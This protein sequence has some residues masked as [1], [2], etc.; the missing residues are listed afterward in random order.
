MTGNKQTRGVRTSECGNADSR[1]A[2]PPEVEEFAVEK[3]IGP[4]LPAVIALA[5]QAFPSASLFVSVGRDTEEER[6]EYIA[7]DIADAVLTAEELLAGQR[8]WSAGITH[9]CPSR[10]AVYFVLGWR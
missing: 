8:F 3:G 2:V 5:Q 1:P 7:F 6:H 10:H 4:Y 9:V